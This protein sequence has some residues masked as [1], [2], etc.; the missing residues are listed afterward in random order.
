MRDCFAGLRG[1]ER[2]VRSLRRGRTPIDD[3]LMQPLL[4]VNCRG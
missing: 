1:A 2:G 3:S 4:F